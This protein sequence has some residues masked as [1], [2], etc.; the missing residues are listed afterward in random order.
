MKKLHREFTRVFKVPPVLHPHLEI[1]ATPEEMA[2]VV[3][4][5][6]E[7][8]TVD[9]IAAKLNLSSAN[10]QAQ[11]DRAFSRCLVNRNMEADGD[12]T[13][14]RA[15]D[16]YGRLSSLAIYD[17]WEGVPTE[18]RQAVVEWDM[19]E[20]ID[21][22]AAVVEQIT[23][24]PDRFVRIPNRDVLLLEEALDQVENATEFAIEVCDCKA[25]TMACNHTREVCILLN[26]GARL[27][28]ERDHGRRISRDEC[29][30]I[31]LDTDR[32]GLIH[33][34]LRDW[35][36]H[37]EGQFAICNCC[38]CCCFP[39]RAGI[40]L[41]RDREWPRA[42]YVARRDPERCKPCGLCAKRCQFDAFTQSKKGKKIE[43]AFDE[44]RCWGCGICATGCP[45]SAIDMLAL[46][47]TETELAG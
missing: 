43:I 27:T 47:Q 10:A 44:A 36:G 12:R 16:F 21:K 25:I 17:N 39:I 40:R 42:H 45:Q 24:D 38:T 7:D 4:L 11:I 35:R 20:F 14:Y 3:S 19:Q 37:P 26:Q 1:I 8:L 30:R 29:K 34:G 2:L 33:T 9:E 6:K 15:S 31:L 41:D 22:H 46:D 23:R 28:L 18:A 13:T 5:E 32:E